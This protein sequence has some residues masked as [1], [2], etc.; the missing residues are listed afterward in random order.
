MA[1]IRTKTHFNKRK[2]ARVYLFLVKDYRSGR[3]RTPRQATAQFLGRYTGETPEQLKERFPGL[4]NELERW[5]KGRQ[6]RIRKNLR[7]AE[8]ALEKSKRHLSLRESGQ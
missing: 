8:Q 5:F 6:S 4:S 1:F 3:A 7:E 2:P